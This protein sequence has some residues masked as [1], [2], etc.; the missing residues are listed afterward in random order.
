MQRAVDCEIAWPLEGVI[1]LI[2]VYGVHSVSRRVGESRPL[3][4]NAPRC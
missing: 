2:T 3:G 4:G 1:T